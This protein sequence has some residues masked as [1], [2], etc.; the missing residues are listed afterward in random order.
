MSCILS[1]T[2]LIYNRDFLMKNVEVPI[3]PLHSNIL[4]FLLQTAGKPPTVDFCPNTQIYTIEGRHQSVKATWE[5]PIF[6]DNVGVV[7]ITKSNVSN[8]V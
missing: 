8:P 6:S 5:E 2:K 4:F 1:L 7:T 3:K